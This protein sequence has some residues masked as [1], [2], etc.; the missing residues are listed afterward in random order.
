MK[1]GQ[2]EREAEGGLS[3]ACDRRDWRGI[4]Y[5]GTAASKARVSRSAQRNQPVGAAGVRGHRSSGNQA[6]SGKVS[7]VIIDAA[8]EA[9]NRAS[10]ATS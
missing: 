6:L 5:R 2:D 1:T 3:G 9:R 8:G 7:P 4:S 10:V